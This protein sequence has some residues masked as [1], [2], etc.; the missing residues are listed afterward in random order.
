MTHRVS[1]DWVGGTDVF[2]LDL[3]GLRSVQTETD[4]GP[5]MLLQKLRY[6]QWRVD[7]VLS[8]LTHGLTRAGADKAASAAR[9]TRMAEQHG[10]QHLVQPAMLVLSAA[11][12]GVPDDAVGETAGE[13]Q[14]PAPAPATNGASAGSTGPEPLPDTGPATSMK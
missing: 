14:G 5:N 4:C 13:D 3:G 6:G 1:L 8:V 2:A 10:I 11:L 9:V 7:D 12:L